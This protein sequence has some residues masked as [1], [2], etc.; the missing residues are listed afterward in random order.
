MTATE[1][2][3]CHE[4]MAA[5]LKKSGCLLEVLK[6]LKLLMCVTPHL[7]MFVSLPKKTK[8]PTGVHM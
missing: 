4:I 7:F 2:Q 5:A 8:L 6:T 3:L 1:R